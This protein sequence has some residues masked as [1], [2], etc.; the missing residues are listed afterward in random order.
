METLST[1]GFGP[2]QLWNLVRLY[3]R[4]SLKKRGLG[5]DS[6]LWLRLSYGVNKGRLGGV[7]FVSKMA[8]CAMSLGGLVGGVYPLMDEF[9]R[10]CDGSERLRSAGCGN[11][12]L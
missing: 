3:W 7:L 11:D 1:S 12:A 6:Q 10:P 9:S 2:N 8:L 5:F 4:S